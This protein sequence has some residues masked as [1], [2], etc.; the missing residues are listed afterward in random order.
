MA[1]AKNSVVI[2]RAALLSDAIGQEPFGFGGGGLPLLG[3][4]ESISP[5]IV[6]WANG[7]KVTYQTDTELHELAA[8]SA[9]AQSFYHH[10][11]LV[12]GVANTPADPAGQGSSEGLVI[13][14]FTLVSG[15]TDYLV[16][17]FSANDVGIF[18]ASSCTLI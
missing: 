10:R 17:Q 2:P 1:L 6:C 5:A 15:T 18:G 13:G 16:V 3:S 8:V 11:V 9:N 7:T 12:S 14:C 4:V